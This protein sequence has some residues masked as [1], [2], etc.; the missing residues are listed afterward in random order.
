MIFRFIC[1]FGRD[2]RRT[3]GAALC[4]TLLLFAGAALAADVDPPKLTD[5]LEQREKD[6]GEGAP[7]VGE[8]EENAIAKNVPT[9]RFERETP[10]G[11]V[12]GYI[13]AA[14]DGD[15]EG[16]AEYLDLRNLP[17]GLDAGKGPQYARQL[18]I[19]LDRALWIDLDQ[20][21]AD[22]DGHA[23]DRLPP[24]R[25]WVGAIEVDGEPIDILLQRVR[26]GSGEFGWKFSNATLGE[27]PALYSVLTLRFLPIHNR[28]RQPASIW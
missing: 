23:D 4:L 18:K 20:L 3:L 11:A 8:G 17:R 9:N 14:R 25:D 19:V 15:Y 2:P 28:R 26:L 6:Q 13:A 24:S 22:P 5:V 12:R 21:S 7:A 1:L 27:V 16:A 10:R